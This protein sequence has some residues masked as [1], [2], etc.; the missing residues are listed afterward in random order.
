MHVNLQVPASDKLH[1]VLSE[2]QGVTKSNSYLARQVVL[3][4]E[5]F[6]GYIWLLLW[7]IALVLS[8]RLLNAYLIHCSEPLYTLII[9][10]GNGNFS[11]LLF[12]SLGV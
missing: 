12:L 1:F 9:C 8:I 6:F 10:F 4:P 3:F 7:K 5:S 11:S 2:E